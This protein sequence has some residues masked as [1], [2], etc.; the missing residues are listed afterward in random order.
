MAMM[1]MIMVTIILG[2][3]KPPNLWVSGVI[4]LGLKR[5]G[6]EAYHLLP[7][8]VEVKNAWNC[9]SPHPIRLHGLMA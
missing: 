4:S 7:S 1:L 6:H 5:P 8:S 3:T 2:P 9:T